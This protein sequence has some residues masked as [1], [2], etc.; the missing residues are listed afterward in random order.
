MPGSD[1]P[2]RAICVY[3]SSSSRV[4]GCYVEAARETGRVIAEA[5]WELVYGGASV[6]LMGELC[7]CARA[8]GARVTGVIP[9]SMLAAGIRSDHVDEMVVA[10]S[11][12]ERKAVM[13]ERAWGFVA[14]P[15]GLGTLEELLETL[16]LK[17]L[18]EHRKPVAVVNTAGYFDPLVDQL[19]RMY[20][21]LFAKEAY[22]ELYAVVE[23]PRT[24]VEYF[25]R[26]VPADLGDKWF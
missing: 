18:G 20:R 8:A 15:G 23:H 16:T 17:Q 4:A 5:G 2:A 14:L 10:E 21:E 11:L 12:R 25:H 19:E 26:Y 6:G 24:A 1:A 9:R 7:R 13:A 22:R 3:C